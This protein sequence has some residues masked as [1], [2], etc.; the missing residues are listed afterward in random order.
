MWALWGIN[1]YIV[2]KPQYSFEPKTFCGNLDE[3][4]GSGQCLKLEKTEVIEGCKLQTTLLGC[5]ARNR[6]VMKLRM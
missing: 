6:S 5:E 2:L 1:I 3:G 4:S